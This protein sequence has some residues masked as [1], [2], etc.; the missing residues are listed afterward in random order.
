MQ[1]DIKND[2]YGTMNDLHVLASCL[3][4]YY[5]QRSIDGLFKMRECGGGHAYSNF[6]SIG[7]W[8]EAWSPNVTLEGDGYVLYQ[9]TTRKLLKILNGSM[10][11]K[12]YNK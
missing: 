12:S 8:I 6:S 7:S 3:K 2:K 1:E 11:G 4:A 9:Q 5:M 10:K